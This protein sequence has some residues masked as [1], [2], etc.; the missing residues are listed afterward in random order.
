MKISVKPGLISGDG[1]ETRPC[2]AADYDA[3]L[4]VE[5]RSKCTWHSLALRVGNHIADIQQAEFC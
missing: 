4:V 2:L 3:D 1:R 5:S